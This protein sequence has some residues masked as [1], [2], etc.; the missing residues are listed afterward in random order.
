MNMLEPRTAYSRAEYVRERA[1]LSDAWA[2]FLAGA[3]GTVI[4][5]RGRSSAAK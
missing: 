4:A 2:G 5:L 1:A 3:P